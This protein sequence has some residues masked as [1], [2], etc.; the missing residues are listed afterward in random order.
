[1][2]ASLSFYCPTSRRDSTI[3]NVADVG[4]SMRAEAALQYDDEIERPA[5]LIQVARFCE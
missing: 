4:N 3:A 1:M 5:E 2:L